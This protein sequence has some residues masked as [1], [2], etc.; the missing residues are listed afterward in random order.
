MFMSS[1]WP[2][3]DDSRSTTLPVYSSDTWRTQNASTLHSA[4]AHRLCIHPTF[5]S[6][7]QIVHS[8]Y[9]QQPPTYP[10]STLHSA[11]AHRLCIHPT[12]SSRPHTRHP[13]YIQQPPTYPAS[14]LHSAAAHRLG[15]H[16]TFSNRS[17][18]RNQ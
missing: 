10:A 7:L 5:S 6:R 11:T 13:P 4:T 18:H 8:P 1:I 3:R 15:I 9:I 16:P 14:T 12:F 17:F 2:L